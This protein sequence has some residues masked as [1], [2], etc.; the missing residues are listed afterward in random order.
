MSTAVPPIPI[1]A[2]PAR[3]S[4]PQRI[5]NAFFAPSRTF[6]DIRHNASWWVPW[7]LGSIIAAAFFFTVDKKIGFETIAKNQMENAG[8]FA[9]R[10]MER[11]TPEQRS[12]ALHR[13][14]I[15]QRVGTLYFSW[16]VSLLF[17]ML[18][19]VVLMA[20]FNFLLEANIPFRQA[21]AT[22]FYA[23]LPRSLS[24]ILGI[25]VLLIG[26]DS[27]AYDLGNPVASNLAAFLDPATFGKFL[28][29]LGTFIDVFSIWTVILLGMGFA[30]QSKKKIST[31]TGI[32]TVAILFMICALGFAGLAAL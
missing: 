17:S 26:V 3:L 28:Y 32:M 27:A 14:A 2:A 1:E 9:Q 31:T 25:V 15:G 10:A 13:Q 6:Q 20:V 23:N 5:A 30:K 24:L 7:L 16:L 8:G 12:Q 22:V 18:I 11:L 21:L 4:E 29:R 19:A